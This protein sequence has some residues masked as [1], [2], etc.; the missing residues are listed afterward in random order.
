MIKFR[1]KERNE[2]K[3]ILKFRMIGRMVILI[4]KRGRLSC[5]VGLVKK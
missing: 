1:V 3:V 2:L 4:I 5:G